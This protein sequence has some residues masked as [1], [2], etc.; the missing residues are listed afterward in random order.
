MFKEQQMEK[1]FWHVIGLIGLAIWLLNRPA[2][3]HF[4]HYRRAFRDPMHFHAAREFKRFPKTFHDD[5]FRVALSRWIRWR[6]HRL[7]GPFALRRVMFATD[8]ARYRSDSSSSSK[9][10]RSAG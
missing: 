8:I 1:R 10:R 6:R 9:T 5:S 2:S 7:A 4:D 3:R